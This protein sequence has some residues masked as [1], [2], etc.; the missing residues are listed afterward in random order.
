MGVGDRDDF[1]FWAVWSSAYLKIAS[2]MSSRTNIIEKWGPFFLSHSLSRLMNTKGMNTKGAGN[3]NGRAG[4]SSFHFL[5]IPCEALWCCISIP[6]YFTIVYVPSLSSRQVKKIKKLLGCN[7]FL[8]YWRGSRYSSTI[9]SQIAHDEKASIF[10]QR[11]GRPT[12]NQQKH[13]ILVVSSC[14]D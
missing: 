1:F 10:W 8:R 4:I 12:V 9:I 2:V 14:N 13:L 11:S 5:W 6:I 7:V 3:R